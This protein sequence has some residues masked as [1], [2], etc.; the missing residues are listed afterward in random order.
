[1]ASPV[2]AAA[3][4]PGVAIAFCGPNRSVKSRCGRRQNCRTRENRTPAPHARPPPPASCPSSRCPPRQSHRPA[5]GP[6]PDTGP[7][8]VPR[9]GRSGIV[10]LKS[11]NSCP[12]IL[13]SSGKHRLLKENHSSDK[14][15]I[16]IGWVKGNCPVQVR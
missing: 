3:T 4:A 8:T 7:A 10:F 11:A 6:N 5:P 2:A 12:K 14:E 15:C 1:M 13:K 16:F 9:C